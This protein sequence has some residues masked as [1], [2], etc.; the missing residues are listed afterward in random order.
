MRVRFLLKLLAGFAVFRTVLTLL[1]VLTGAGTVTAYAFLYA[2]MGVDVAAFVLAL[3]VRVAPERLLRHRPLNGGAVA[4]C[5][6]S[7][8]VWL[9]PAASAAALVLPLTVLRLTGLMP[10]QSVPAM[11]FCAMLLMQGMLFLFNRDADGVA[12]PAAR[13]CVGVLLF[14]VLPVLTAAVLSA[15]LPAVA[16]VTELGAWSL[17]S[18]VLLAL[19]PF[20]VLLC[21]LLLSRYSEPAG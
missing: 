11:L 21:T 10:E 19:S 18:A 14:L 5:L 2:S 16:A 12:L 8:R 15:L 6:R 3:R 4:A 7:R 20:L 13:V 9:I 17:S 1:C